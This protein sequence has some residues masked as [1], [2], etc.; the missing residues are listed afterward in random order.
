MTAGLP[1]F[2]LGGL[3]FILSALLAP[4]FELPATLRGRSSRARWTRIASN[5][6]LALAMIVAVEVALLILVTALGG[7]AT[8]GAQATVANGGGAHGVAHTAG[9]GGLALAPLPVPPIAVTVALL[10]AILGIAKLADI[11]RR[12]RPRV[13]T[14][15]ARV[16]PRSMDPAEER[17]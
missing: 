6:A 3:F 5:L 2:G 12:T 7:G 14:L 15:R 4:I 1:G 10:G 8:H 17:A 13:Q 11:V 9:S 16:R